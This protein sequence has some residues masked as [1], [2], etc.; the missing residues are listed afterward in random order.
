MELSN[1]EK[2]K[3]QYVGTGVWQL[4]NYAEYLSEHYQIY[5]LNKVCNDVPRRLFGIL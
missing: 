3:G 5:L 1:I 4:E 2:L